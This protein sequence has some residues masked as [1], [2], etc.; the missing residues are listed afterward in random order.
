MRGFVSS[1]I[2]TGLLLGPQNHLAKPSQEVNANSSQVNLGQR[3]S[4]CEKVRI[5]LNSGRKID[6]DSYK[7]QEDHVDV[8]KKG[9]IQTLSEKDIKR[10]DVRQGSCPDIVLMLKT[11][12]K[13]LGYRR[14]HTCPD[15]YLCKTEVS[16]Q[17]NIRTIAD[18]DIK[19]V[20]LKFKKTFAEQLKNAAL[21]P[22]H[23]FS[24]LILFIL[25]STGGCD[26]L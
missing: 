10:I 5:T 16:R 24:Y 20:G 1:L 22:V 25:C 12:E 15:R 2:A 9:A 13:I 7:Q 18:A 4:E 26:D 23:G 8:I 21:V 19:T 6:A 3:P 17:G 11:G 14:D